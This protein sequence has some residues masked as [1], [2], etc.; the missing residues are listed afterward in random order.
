MCLL[1]TNA[2]R[3][4]HEAA[5]NLV[6]PNQWFADAVDARQVSIPFFHFI[7]FIVIIQ[8]KI[9]FYFIFGRKL[10]FELVLHSLGFKQCC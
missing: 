7:F 5:Q 3:E 4:I 1:F 8:K 2:A 10:I 9:I 6:A